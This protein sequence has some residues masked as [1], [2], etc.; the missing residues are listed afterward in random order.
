MAP[1]WLRRHGVRAA[2]GLLAAA[3][4][5]SGVLL[6]VWG[7]GGARPAPRAP[8]RHANGLLHVAEHTVGVTATLAH[9]REAFTQGLA[10]H[11]DGFLYESTG[12]YGRSSVR[13]L[14]PRADNAV[15][16]R[17]HLPDELFGEGLT[18]SPAGDEAVQLTWRERTGIVYA[19]PSLLEKRRFTFTTDSGE[20]WG[21]THNGSHYIVSDG[22]PTL[23][24]WDPA[25]MREVGRISVHASEPVPP[26]HRGRRVSPKTK[27]KGA[28][29]YF[30]SRLNELEFV[31]GE[32]LANV[33]M[34]DTI[35]RICPRTGEVRGFIN[36][37]DLLPAAERHGG[38]DVLNG[39]A[40]DAA[41]GEL[42]VT[43]KL[44]PRMFRVAVD[45]VPWRIPA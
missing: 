11:T 38:E 10:L 25:T 4:V 35:V 41:T 34:T 14:D 20:G 30:V 15:V 29:P 40:Y 22:S 31:R 36:L 44:W 1:A 28:G 8:A 9:D 16:T 33:W 27:R 24:Y 17:R 37:H 12:L 42:L 21:I 45:G 32:V 2:G 43:G 6:A 13:R 5:C 26:A 18:L 23:Y 7:T 19:V 39:I 3:L